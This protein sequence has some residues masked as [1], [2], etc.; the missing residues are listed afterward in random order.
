MMGSL[1][2]AYD[3]LAKQTVYRRQFGEN[4]DANTTPISNYDVKKMYERWSKG[5]K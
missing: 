4:V 2:E 3:E 5:E 1:L